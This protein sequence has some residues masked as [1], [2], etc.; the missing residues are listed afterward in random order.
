MLWYHTFVDKL[1]KDGFQ[2]NKYDPCV[3]NKT[4]N[5]EQC[6]ICWYVDD[7]KVSH[8]DP[9][10]VDKVLASMEGCFNK[11]TIKR[12]KSH[13]FVGIDFTLNKNGT[14]SIFMKDYINE[15]ID[16]FGRND[17]KKK[18]STPARHDLFDTNEKSNKIDSKR[19]EIFHHIV[20]KLLYVSKR[21]RL[22]IETTISFLCT[23]VT[24]CDEDDWEKLRRLLGYLKNTLELPRIIGADS[25]SLMRSWADASFAVHR[26]MKSHT[27][28]TS[29]FGIGVVH[30]KCSKQKINT[31]SSTEA[32]IVAASDYISHTIWIANFMKDQGYP[33]SKKFFY[34][35][36]K[37]AIQ[38]EKN[39]RMSSSERSRHINI[40]FFSIKDVLER[41]GIDIKHC[42]TE[43]MIAD[44]F[45][46]PLQGLLFTEIR[47]IIMGNAPF[48][49]EERVGSSTGKASMS[50][51][52]ECHRTDQV[53][54]EV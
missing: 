48:P 36:N 10:V 6:T 52:T 32:E 23:R 14:V 54:G 7:T 39:G 29:S 9:K 37:S 22:D 49:M 2:L 17:I 8:K 30:S 40:R 21:A 12:G 47:Y 38:V 19:A 53:D 35:D 26:D 13:T 24:K 50:I 33:I 31:K 4:I 20:A 46:K 41:E 3:A 5:G 1:L 34:Q 18:A 45:T 27:G 11:M 42:G 25:L 15:C 28:G 43:K 44:Y 16:V 51:G